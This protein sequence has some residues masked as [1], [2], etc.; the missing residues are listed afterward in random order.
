[1]LGLL[2][3]HNSDP[4]S[5]FLIMNRFLPSLPHRTTNTTW[6]YNNRYISP[7]VVSLASLTVPLLAVVEGLMLGVVAPPGILFGVGAA[8]ILI[9]AA[10]ASVVTMLPHTEVGTSMA[11]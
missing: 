7:L 2:G 11:E 6:R 9:G 4:L 1:M 3:F 5:N 10:T 8:L